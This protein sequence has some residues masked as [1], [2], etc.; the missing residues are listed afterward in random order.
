MAS[1]ESEIVVGFDQQRLWCRQ[2]GQ[3]EQSILW[4]ELTAVAIRTTDEGPVAPDVFWIL[5]SKEKAI[6][7]PGGAT[8]EDEMLSRLQQLPNFNHDAV[9]SAAACAENSIFVCWD[10][11]AQTTGSR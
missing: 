2:P 3:P 10:K 1:P 6:I 9:I 8:G 7:Y 11:A 4:S 5:R